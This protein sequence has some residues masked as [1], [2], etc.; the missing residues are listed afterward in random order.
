MDKVLPRPHALQVEETWQI[1]THVDSGYE[2]HETRET[3]EVEKRISTYSL[4]KVILVVLCFVWN[5]GRNEGLACW[6]VKF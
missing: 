4:V 5:A 6:T 1:Q 3:Q 2:D